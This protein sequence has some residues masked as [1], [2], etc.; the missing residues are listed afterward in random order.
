MSIFDVTQSTVAAS[1]VLLGQL[2]WRYNEDEIALKELEPA[3]PILQEYD[4]AK[5][6]LDSDVSTHSLNDIDV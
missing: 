5:T 1:R 4:V 6:S 3:C 2:F